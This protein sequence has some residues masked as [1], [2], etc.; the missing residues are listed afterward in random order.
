MMTGIPLDAIIL[1]STK[2]DEYGSLDLDDS[3]NRERLD[4]LCAE[5]H[6]GLIVID[7]VGGTTSKKLT[8][9]DDTSRS[10]CRSSI[11]PRRTR[12]AFW[13]SRTRTR[14][15]ISLVFVGEESP[16]LFGSLRFPIRCNL[17][18]VALRLKETF[19]SP[20]SSGSHFS[21]IDASTISI[22]RA[23]AWKKA[24]RVVV[25]REKRS[26]VRSWPG[27][28]RVSRRKITR[29]EPASNKMAKSIEIIR[30]PRSG[31]P[32]KISGRRQ[33]HE[34]RFPHHAPSRQRE[35]DPVPL[36]GNVRQRQ[37]ETGSET[38]I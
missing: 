22:L 20:L 15:E 29:V 3:G 18:D 10:I 25:V 9:M 11:S 12:R 13:V 7:T 19:G 32:S 34:G 6:P 24:S 35:R 4:M 16:E 5:Y 21:T 2:G 8:L 37:R 1:N 14:K 23:P 28:W 31:E 30:R 36:L 27:S 26:G 38:L 33:D 17:L